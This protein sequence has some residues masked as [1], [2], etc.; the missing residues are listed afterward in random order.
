[1]KKV[2]LYL[3]GFVALFATAFFIYQWN[4]DAPTQLVMDDEQEVSERLS[5]ETE[6]TSTA[7]VVSSESSSKTSDESVES[8]E[9]HISVAES[10][11]TWNGP[12]TTYLN[13]N[14][15]QIA[16]SD[17]LG[18]PTIIN[19]WATWCPPCREEMPLFEEAYQNYGND[20]N[21]VMINALGSRPTETKEVALDF[22]DE[23][24]LSMPIYFDDELNNQLIFGASSLPLTALLDEN[25]I[26]IELIRGQI[27]PAKLKQLI[28][29]AL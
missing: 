20:I 4:S 18:K 10:A 11:L 28:D 8:E 1:M 26:V 5:S 29:I 25:G 16:L 22:A 21:M 24:N 17:N 7:E 2:I 13:A 27:A 14:D 15:E 12:E 19:I 9:S 3:V 6:L 23:I